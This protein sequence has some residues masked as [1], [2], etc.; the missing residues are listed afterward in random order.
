[1]QPQPKIQRRLAVLVL[2]T[3]ALL[4][5]AIPP[6]PRDR[7]LAQARE[8]TAWFYSG[9]NDAELWARLA[10]PMAKAFGGDPARLPL[11]RQQIAS[12]IGNEVELLNERVVPALGSPFQNY[13][14]RARHSSFAGDIETMWTLDPAGMVQGFFVRPVA[15]PAPS[16]FLDYTLKTR[17]RLPF[18]GEWFVY[19]GGRSVYDNYHAAAVDQRFALD[20]VVLKDG[21]DY[22]GDGTRN[23]DY[24][25]FGLP[26]LA[27]AAATVAAAEG[28]HPDNPPPQP[29]KETKLGNHVILD[30]G[31]SEFSFYAHLKQGS[32]RVEPGTKVKQGD[33][34]GECG[35]S[36]NSP[37]PHLHYHLQ[38][39]PVF[40]QGEG[41]PAQ[42]HDYV[43]DGEPVSRGEPVRGQTVRPQ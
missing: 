7:A 23:E 34:L 43:A 33:V 30:H 6:A 35:N 42:F 13:T 9:E 31:N 38:N 41:L 22:T 14:R 28:H 5:H 17:L 11:V 20:I 4:A 29:G 2:L 24:H 39:T 27:S 36:G 8:L 12:Q 25:C 10:P 21:R 3:C 40:A 26:M 16:N 18:D 15:S 1:M 19:Q 37:I 32:V